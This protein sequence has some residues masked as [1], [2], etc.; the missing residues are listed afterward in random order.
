MPDK[1]AS[2]PRV[3]LYRHGET[4]WSRSGRYTG[5]TDLD[6]TDDG[7]RQVL[8]SGRL[9]V[10][11]G[12]LIDPLRLA[13]VFVSPRLRAIRTFELAFGEA[14]KK[15]FED[16]GKAITTP[17]LAEWDYGLYEGL[18]TKEIRAL[19]QGHGLDQER[20]WDIWRDGCESGE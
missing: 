7:E 18:V 6:L 11:P 9:L 2:T 19:R 5:T 14:Q 4:E 10:G 3:F 17:K 20:S 16:A 8:A 15:A 13:R 12:K 1:D